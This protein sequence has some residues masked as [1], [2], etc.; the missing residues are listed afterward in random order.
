MP[1]CAAIFRAAGERDGEASK[2]LC[3]LQKRAYLGFNSMDGKHEE[4]LR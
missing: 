3:S 4:L 2:T 1:A